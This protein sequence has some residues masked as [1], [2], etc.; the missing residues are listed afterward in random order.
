MH[1]ADNSH[2]DTYRSG[3]SV[4]LANPG[5]IRTRLT[6]KN[7]YSMPAIMSPE[8]AAAHVLALMR[9]RRFRADFPHP[10]AWLF[11]LGRLLPTALFYRL[12]RN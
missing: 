6:A 4:Q 7:D 3:V 8:Q 12:I 2:A 5:F 9:S 1:R 11:S 10:F